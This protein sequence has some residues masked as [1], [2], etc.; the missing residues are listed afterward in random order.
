VRNHVGID[1]PPHALTFDDLL[2]GGRA[3]P[4]EL[5]SAL[6]QH[7]LHPVLSPSFKQ[8]CDIRRWQGRGQLIG[9]GRH[10]VTGL[11][12]EV[13][14]KGSGCVH[15]QQT[16]WLLAAVSERVDFTIGDPDEVT[17]LGAARLRSD[18]KLEGAVE[19]I[20][21]L[22]ISLVAVGWWASSRSDKRLD[23]AVPCVRLTDQEPH[24]N[25]RQEVGIG[26]SVRHGQSF[27]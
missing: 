11:R 17:T 18:A 26:L 21:C 16:P 12:E 22:V 6:R 5:C 20:E 15:D 2:D 3:T 13:D 9:T 8:A 23:Q 4:D 27:G 1:D 25:A 24:E 10:R 19:D 7:E 14:V